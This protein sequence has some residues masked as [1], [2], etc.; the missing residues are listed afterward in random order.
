M[1][2]VDLDPVSAMVKLLAGSLARLDWAIDELRALGDVNLRSIPFE[3][4]ATGGR[5]CASDDEHARTGNEST[6]D[7]LL[8][9]DVAIAGAFGL[10]IANGSEALFQAAS[11]GGAGAGGAERGRILQ[12]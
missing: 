2:H 12:K 9:A 7:G 1:R 10:D 6:F 4:I 8:D 11:R 3:G 5:N